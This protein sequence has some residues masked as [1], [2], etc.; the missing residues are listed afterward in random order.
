MSS[1]QTSPLT[2]PTWRRLVAFILLA[3]SEFML[4]LDSTIVNVAL[5]TIS[6]DLSMTPGELSWVVNAYV[7]AICGFLL[8]G[9]RLGDFFGHRR[10]FVSGLALFTAS[11]LVAG[12]AGSGDVL[13]AAR[14]LQGLG[15]AL[16][17]PASL[18]IVTTTF[19]DGESRTRALGARG[20]IAAAGGT[21]G[22][23][24]GGIVTEIFGWH[25]IFWLNVPV[26]V[27]TIALS[28]S[29]LPARRDS[30][31]KRFDITG[32][33]L[34]VTGMT[35]LVYGLVEAAE[36]HWGA[37]TSVI[38]L[39]AGAVL[40][41]AFGIVQATR[42]DPLLPRA[43]LRVR[44]RRGSV[45]GALSIGAALYA[46]IFFITLYMQIVLG[47]TPIEAGLAYL[48]MGFATIISAAAGS[49]LSARLGAARVLALGLLSGCA[50]MVWLWT[51]PV[52]GAF[53]A[54]VLGPTVLLGTAIGTSFVALTM[55][56]TAGVASDRTGL[57]SGV[58]QTALQTGYALGLAVLATAFM[59]TSGIQGE[60]SA[61]AVD[62][63]TAVV[64]GVSAAMLVAAGVN[65]VGAVLVLVVAGKRRP[66][67]DTVAPA[68]IAPTRSGLEVATETAMSTKAAVTAS[69]ASPRQTIATPQNGASETLR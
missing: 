13:I 19:P 65:A 18:A 41:V 29:F 14:A 28:P 43:F 5:P 57:A 45:V 21:L 11:S 30:D 68:S 27:A 16:V 60:L 40:L 61:M 53:V 17:A 31:A 59:G 55:G 54:D 4:V 62:S 26:G 8:L 44:L 20:A 67:H 66:A 39:A 50:G 12:A 37:T 25:W 69:S 46:P 9:G 10:M 23:I 42:R 38:G 2:I 6:G 58:M 32:A 48:P 49:A 52:E 34:A 3:G 33:L 64:D 51:V 15:A 1:P 7:L 24:V 35:A 56:I 22:V 47:W 36:D 63:L